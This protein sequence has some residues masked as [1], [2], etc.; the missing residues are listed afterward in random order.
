M[1]Q[2]CKGKYKNRV[3]GAWIVSVVDLTIKTL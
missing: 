1:A 3:R 2:I